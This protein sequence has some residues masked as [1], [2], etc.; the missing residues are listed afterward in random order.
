M[1]KEEFKRLFSKIFVR[2][3]VIIVFLIICYFASFMFRLDPVFASQADLIGSTPEE[4][5]MELYPNATS[6]TPV[7]GGESGYHPDIEYYNKTRV[8]RWHTSGTYSNMAIN[9]TTPYK[10]RDSLYFYLFSADKIMSIRGNTGQCEFKEI[11]YQDLS[12]TQIA[13]ANNAPFYS[14]GYKVNCY[15]FLDSDTQFREFNT[16]KITI[17]YS[18]YKNADPRIFRPFFYDSENKDSIEAIKEESEKQ[19]QAINGVKGS[20]DTTNDILND[21]KTDGANDKGDDFFN[22]FNFEFKGGLTGILTAPLNTIASLTGSSCS[23]I[24]LTIPF[25]NKQMELPCM[26]TIY[27]RFGNFF[28]AYQIITFG[29]IGYWIIVKTFKIIK[30]MVNPDDDKVEVLDL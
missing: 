9:I 17:G 25:V 6:N 15:A 14:S 19:I 13:W 11:Y 20:I 2:I 1:I 24:T 27:S 22:E 26:T 18:D 29:I 3:I 10:D 16:L 30:D 28:T 8:Y 7:W 23:P 12:G 21:D 5:S 4:L